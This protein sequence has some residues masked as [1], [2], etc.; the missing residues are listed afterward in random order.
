[1]PRPKKKLTSVPQDIGSGILE[2]SSAYG[3]TSAAV[4][5][6]SEPKPELNT[7]QSPGKL[8][9]E[10]A[11]EEAREAELTEKV[12]I[13][14]VA[15]SK[16]KLA[17]ATRL[18]DAK[19]K[20]LAPLEKHKKGE[21]AI[22]RLQKCRTLLNRIIK[23]KDAMWDAKEEL[24]LAERIAAEAAKAARQARSAAQRLHIKRLERLL[25]RA[26]RWRR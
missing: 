1:M 13:E 15:E 26:V 22:Q 17:F 23:I 25:K 16:S 7:V 4:V 20:R 6:S 11:E 2:A 12:S 21:K 18:R 19:I 10:E 9:C 8:L 14:L 24:Y 5:T 3:A